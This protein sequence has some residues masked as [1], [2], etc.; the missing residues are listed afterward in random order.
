MKKS[1]LFFIFIAGLTVS[2]PEAMAAREVLDANKNKIAI[3]VPKNW[4]SYKNLNGIPISIVSEDHAPGNSKTRAEYEAERTVIGIIP[5]PEDLEKVKFEP[6]DFEEDFD[7]YVKSKKESISELDG[8]FISSE[9]GKFTETKNSAGQELQFFKQGVTYE[10]MNSKLNDLTY[11]LT[12]DGK[13]FMVKVIYHDGH[14][15]E[16][17]ATVEKV[18]QEFECL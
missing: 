14:R 15:S 11:H 16:D 1:V 8:K 2:L 18:I 7:D 6:K 12:C 5:G 4:K 3:Q 17:E 10:A 13:Y 9:K